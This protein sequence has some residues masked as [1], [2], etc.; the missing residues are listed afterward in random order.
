MWGGRSGGPQAPHSLPR[1]PLSPTNL[2]RSLSVSCGLLSFSSSCCGGGNGTP[3]TCR[4]RVSGEPVL[5]RTVSSRKWVTSASAVL[6][7]SEGTDVDATVYRRCCV[8]LG[9]GS[10]PDTGPRAKKQKEKEGR[11]GAEER[12]MVMEQEDLEHC[13]ADYLA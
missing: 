10:A 12:R 1:P 5:S 3:L 9:L 7:P 8:C 6:A 13:V 4:R 2:A 11:K